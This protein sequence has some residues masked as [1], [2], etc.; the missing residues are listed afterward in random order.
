MKAAQQQQQGAADSSRARTTPR[1]LQWQ[2]TEPLPAIPD[3]NYAAFILEIMAGYGDAVAVVEAETGRQRTYREV[4]GLVPRVSAG[5]A[6]AGVVPGDTVLFLTPTIMDYPLVFLSIVHRGATCVPV[7]ANLSTDELVH[8]VRVSKA[9]WAV[10]HEDSLE[11]AEAAFSLMPPGTL[12]QLWVLGDCATHRPNLTHLMTYSPAPPFTKAEGLEASTAVAMMPFSSGTTGLPKG[13]MLSHRNLLYTHVRLMS[14]VKFFPPGGVNR[15]NASNTTLVILPVCH[16]Y[17]HL[18]VFSV[19]HIGSTV[20]FLRKFAPRKYFEAIQNFKVTFSPLVPHL[21]KFLMETPLLK[22]Y[23]VSAVSFFSAGAPL[24]ASTANAFIKKIG[25]PVTGGYGL[26]ETTAIAT[27]NKTPNSSNINSVGQV[28]PYVQV[29]VVDVESGELVAEGVEGEVCVRG[30]NIM[31]GYANDPVAT[32]ATIDT[33]GWLHTGDIGYYDKDDFL[34]LTDRIKDLIKV[35]G[36]QVSPTELEN[37][38]RK[39]EGVD[40]VAVVGVPH[41]KMGEAPRA[42]VVLRPGSAV[43]PHHLQQFLAERVAQYKRLAGGVKLVASIPRNST[44]KVLRRQL[45]EGLSTPAAKL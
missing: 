41:E 34:Y 6:A 1:L 26:T 9:S 39:N 7:N 11:V 16:L 32:A 31:L 30:P 4:C 18:T 5:L 17:G 12:R 29:K 38:L 24:T 2:G 14:E 19:L 23:D 20:V 22:E 42:Y 43:R 25:R 15:S 33:D 8:V 28:A 27:S 36:Y 21:L 45:V 44:G 35:K 3:T 10:V 37:I 13:V 40:D